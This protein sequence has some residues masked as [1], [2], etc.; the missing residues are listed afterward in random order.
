MVITNT[1]ENGNKGSW[2]GT[3]QGVSGPANQSISKALRITARDNLE[4]KNVIP[5]VGGQKVRIRFWYNPLGL[6]EAYFRVGFI[7]NRKDGNK[8][9]PS[10]TV[11]TGPAPSSSWT[12]FDQELTLGATDEGIAWPWFQLDNK[13]SGASL[14]Y[15]LIA[16]IHFEDLS[17]DGA[18][19]NI[20]DR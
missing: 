13:T 2:A 10:R 8:G 1:F 14:G 17:M 6:E 3:L 20:T 16:D 19:G 5:V 9:Y 7:V 4:G 18:D 11:V 12:Y 15:M